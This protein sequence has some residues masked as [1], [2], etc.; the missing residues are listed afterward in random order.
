MFDKTGVLTEGRPRL[1]DAP[2]DRLDLET[3]LADRLRDFRPELAVVVASMAAGIV[4]GLIAAFSE[5]ALSTLI[6]RAMDVILSV[7]SLILCIVV[8]AIMLDRMLRVRGRHD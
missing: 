3:L 5:S 2:A 7:P 6:L 4:L 1:I 8:V